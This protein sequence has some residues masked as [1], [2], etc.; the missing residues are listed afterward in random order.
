MPKNGIF[1]IGIESGVLLDIAF[2]LYIL[3]VTFLFVLIVENHKAALLRAVL[4]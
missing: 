3:V 4:S 1:L 2:F